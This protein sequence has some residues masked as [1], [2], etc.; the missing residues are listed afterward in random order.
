M[1]RLTPEELNANNAYKLLAEVDHRAVKP[2]ILSQIRQGSELVRWF[3]L[4]Q[5]VMVLLFIFLVV[6]A[7]ILYWHGVDAPLSDLG[8]SVVFSFT[9]LIIVHEGLH[10]LAYFLCGV[11]K[12]RAGAVWQKFIFY[13]LADRQVIGAR[14]FFIVALAPFIVIKVVCF[15]LVVLFRNTDLFYFFLGVMCIHSLFCAGDIAMIAF[16]R[17]HADKTILNFD[18]RKLGKTFFYYLDKQL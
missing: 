15:G 14:T 8:L 9:L 6:K 5:G 4:Y 7:L 11:R 10:A 17:Q 12:I 2:F 13:V 1:I 18:D 16:Y 3:S